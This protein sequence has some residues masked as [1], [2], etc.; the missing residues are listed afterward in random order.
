[1]A[2]IMIDTKESK[3]PEKSLAFAST[4]AKIKL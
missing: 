1:M 4:F 3:L 2:A